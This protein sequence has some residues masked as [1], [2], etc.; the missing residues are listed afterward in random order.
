MDNPIS[1]AKE[2]EG[3][4]AE[5]KKWII[6]SID[7]K[8]PTGEAIFLGIQHY[9]T[10]FGATVLIPLILANAMKM[11]ADQTALLISTIF[12]VS[13]ITTW[14]QSTIGNRLPVIQGGS[15]SFL[16]PAFVIIGATV[17]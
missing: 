10:M 6:Y 15:F 2:K 9:L 1:G 3:Y 7:D 11:P 13:G 12:L 17:G 16:P 14:L 4:M 8:P 5:E